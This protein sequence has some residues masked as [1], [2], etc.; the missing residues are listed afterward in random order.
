MQIG[1]FVFS[2]G[3]PR[4]RSIFGTSSLILAT[5][6][7]VLLP[8][9]PPPLHGADLEWPDRSRCR[10]LP[11]HGVDGNRYGHD[12]GESRPN[13]VAMDYSP[14]KPVAFK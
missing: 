7:T 12:A 3:S 1:V 11:G 10:Y 6:G 9:R 2:T 13:E 8:L 5:A 14:R 4:V